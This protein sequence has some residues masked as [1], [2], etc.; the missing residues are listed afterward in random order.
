MYIVHT[1]VCIFRLYCVAL[2]PSL[3]SSENNNNVFESGLFFTQAKLTHTLTHTLANSH[4]FKNLYTYVCKC[5]LVLWPPVN[6]IVYVLFTCISWGFARFFVHW[7]TSDR[8]QKKLCT[9][10]L[11][12]KRKTK[13]IENQQV[14]LLKF[15]Y[16][17]TR[18]IE[19][20]LISICMHVCMYACALKP[21]KRKLRLIAYSLLCR[22]IK[23]AYLSC[24]TYDQKMREIILFQL[25]YLL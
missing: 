24:C 25:I 13:T 16:T 21:Q 1:F 5:C 19:R 20:L 15:K 14:R 10:H 11:H 2:L 22:A 4:T 3:S 17:Y 8:F 9:K 6:V 18:I 7:Q 12:S 23:F